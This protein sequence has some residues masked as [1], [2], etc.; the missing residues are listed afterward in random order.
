[1][2]RQNKVNP[3]HYTQGGR[4]SPDDLARE[5]QKQEPGGVRPSR[6]DRPLPPWMR[7]THPAAPPA[8]GVE[9]PAREADRPEVSTVDADA[10]AR[11]AGAAPRRAAKKVTRRAAKSR[12][13][14]RVARARKAKTATPR[15]KKRAKK[16]AVARSAKKAPARSR[17]SRAATKRAASTRARTTRVRNAKKR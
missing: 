8:I 9:E 5:R 6:R 7:G 12:P 3:D 16:T 11:P 2:S 17:T 4:L 13:A 14:P 10:D 1:M 15:A